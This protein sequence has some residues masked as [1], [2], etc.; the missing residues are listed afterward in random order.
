MFEAQELD[1]KKVG[2]RIRALRKSENLT[3]RDFAHRIG[4]TTALVS[5]WERG[6]NRPKVAQAA[7]IVAQFDV[8]LD[9]L[10]LGDVDTLK[11]GVARALGELE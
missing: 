4:G 6:D 5:N 11:V 3:Q 8:T 10:Y 7:Y 1:P 2:A 9:W